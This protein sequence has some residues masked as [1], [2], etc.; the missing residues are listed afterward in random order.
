MASHRGGKMATNQVENRVVYDCSS[1]AFISDTKNQ[2]PLKSI[3][4]QKSDETRQERP[5]PRPPVKPDG[6]VKPKPQPMQ[7]P[8]AE[9]TEN[10]SPPKQQQGDAQGEYATARELEQAK[11][12]AS[13][14]QRDGRP[15]SKQP[16][17]QYHK[18]AQSKGKGSRR[19]DHDS[20]P[21]N[22][23]L[24]PRLQKRQQQQ[25]QQRLQQQ[26]QHQ[27]HRQ[28]NPEL[29]TED[30]TEDQ[31]ASA[32]SPR[33][34]AQDDDAIVRFST[35]PASRQNEYVE[36]PPGEIPPHAQF[37]EPQGRS[38]SYQQQYNAQAKWHKTYRQGSEHYNPQSFTPPNVQQQQQQHL[39]FVSMAMESQRMQTQFV[40]NQTQPFVERAGGEQ[41]DIAM[42]QEYQYVQQAQAPVQ[43]YPVYQMRPAQIPQ[44]QA[45]AAQQTVA[46]P[47]VASPIVTTQVF[48][49]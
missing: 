4:N 48:S 45:M 23:S 40:V 24:P 19:H 25:Q 38:S 29:D 39:E 36:E 30:G 17:E 32:I 20:R 11:H 1:F 33:S 34:V 12:D 46:R 31:G 5:P 9:K 7:D 43:T 35:A 41:T 16:R 13:P 28:N 3:E 42:P 21:Y 22:Q 8:K 26:Q 6:D 47:V 37:Q 49:R 10:S 27:H 14:H 44:Q 15:Q 18:Q 2:K